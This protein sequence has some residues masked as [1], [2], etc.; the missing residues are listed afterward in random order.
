MPLCSLLAQ[1]SFGIMKEPAL[2][3]PSGHP[4]A[5]IIPWSMG[6]S[7]GTFIGNEHF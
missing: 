4:V 6:L 2:Y 7:E 3:F 5:G 1:M